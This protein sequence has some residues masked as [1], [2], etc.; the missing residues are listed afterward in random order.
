MSK[1]LVLAS[2]P[3]GT[4]QLRL[5]REIRAIEDAFRS[6]E[7]RDRFTV[8]SRVAV[9]ISDLQSFLRREK[10]RIVHFC[11]HGTG[12]QGL[13]LATESGKQQT[14]GTQAL[15][16]LFRLFATRV[17]CVVLNACYSD[18]QGEAIKQ[19]INHVIGTKRAI[20]DEAA[21]AFAKG[22]YEALSDGESF[23]CAY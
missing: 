3:Q 8:I 23:V 16:D 15:A 6:G 12:N 9:K 17:D 20:L 4:D 10:P 21:I 13:V 22:F 2:N 14:V 7:K 18:V 11:G 5:D 1:I 19:H